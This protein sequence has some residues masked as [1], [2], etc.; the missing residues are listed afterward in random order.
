MAE[1][2]LA[3]ELKAGRVWRARWHGIQFPLGCRPEVCNLYSYGHFIRGIAVTSGTMGVSVRGT[4]RGWNRDWVVRTLSVYRAAFGGCSETAFGEGMMPGSA[5]S[6]RATMNF[7]DE[8]ES[9]SNH[10]RSRLAPT[11]SICFRELGGPLWKIP[12]LCLN[13]RAHRS[14]NCGGENN[15]YGTVY[16]LQFATK[17]C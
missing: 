17:R 6:K 8:A 9:S 3:W 10:V 4:N 14:F 1:R 12:Q 13:S 7:G 11:S 2:R 15:E 5:L 16:S